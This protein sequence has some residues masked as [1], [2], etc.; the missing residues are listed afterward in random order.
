MALVDGAV[1]EPAEPFSTPVR[2]LPE[3]WSLRALTA[4]MSTDDGAWNGDAV[5]G[6]R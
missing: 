2:D 1:V 3:I 4:G 5:V 6:G